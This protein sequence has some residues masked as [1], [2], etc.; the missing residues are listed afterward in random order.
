MLLG[1]QKSLGQHLMKE[2]GKKQT[3]T[4]NYQPDSL[5]AAQFKHHL[6]RHRGA[7]RGKVLMNQ[8]NL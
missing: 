5:Q 4:Q 8:V 1:V 6:L 2:K 7:A 3:N